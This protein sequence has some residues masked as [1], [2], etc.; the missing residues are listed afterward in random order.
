MAIMGF[1]LV[2]NRQ[3]IFFDHSCPICEVQ[4]PSKYTS[5]ISQIP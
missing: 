1:D 3:L 5:A 2:M 4:R